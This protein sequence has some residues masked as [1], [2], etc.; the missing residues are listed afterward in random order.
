MYPLIKFLSLKYQREKKY[1]AASEVGTPDLK[2]HLRYARIR[3]NFG[4]RLDF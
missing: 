3:S 2:G 4:I 1:S